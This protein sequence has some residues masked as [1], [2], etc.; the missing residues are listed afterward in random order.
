MPSPVSSGYTCMPNPLDHNGSSQDSIDDPGRN[1]TSTLVRRSEGWSAHPVSSNIK[2]EG[3]DDALCMQGSLIIQRAWQAF[4]RRRALR[5]ARQQ[6]HTNRRVSGVDEDVDV[7]QELEIYTKFLEPKQKAEAVKGVPV[8][9]N[10]VVPPEELQGSLKGTWA[11]TCRLIDSWLLFGLAV[12]FGI[13]QTA[14]SVLLAGFWVTLIAQVFP[15]Q[16]QAA[17]VVHHSHPQC[18]AP[19]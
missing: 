17:H 13:A 18:T 15:Q 14:C 16:G 11:A 5:I 7:V 1:S 12:L 8:E 3:Q 19:R 9:L 2:V 4:K 10:G 6:L